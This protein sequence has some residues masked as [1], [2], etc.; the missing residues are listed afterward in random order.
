M[1]NPIS[2]RISSIMLGAKTRDITLAPD[3]EVS[4]DN[5]LHDLFISDLHLGGRDRDGK[6]FTD[7]DAVIGLLQ[8]V[9]ANTIHSVGDFAQFLRLLYWEAPDHD[10]KVEMV[11]KLLLEHK[12]AGAT[13]NWYGGNHDP[14][15]DHR[16]AIDWQSAA[17]WFSKQFPFNLMHHQ[18][19][20]M[21]GGRY[22]VTHGQHLDPRWLFLHDVAAHHGLKNV[23]SW[24]DVRS[25]K[26]Q[27]VPPA[28]LEKYEEFVDWTKGGKPQPVTIAVLSD[29]LQEQIAIQRFMQ[30]EIAKI[31]ELR[32]DN[33]IT[34]TVCGHW[35]RPADESI[36]GIHH[37]NTG[38]WVQSAD[39]PGRSL[40]ATRHKGGVPMLAH[41]DAEAGIIKSRI[42]NDN[43]AGVDFASREKRTP[44]VRGPHRTAEWAADEER[45]LIVLDIDGT[46]YDY[47]ELQKAAGGRN[48]FNEAALTAARN[49]FPKNKFPDMTDKKILDLFARSFTQRN[50]CASAFME[51]AAE[52]GLDADA[53]G[54]RFSRQYHEQLW[55]LASS[56]PDF[57]DHIRPTVEAIKSMSQKRP[58]E[59]AVLTHSHLDA[60]GNPFL[61]RAGLSAFIPPE[62]RFSTKD[63]GGKGK[64]ESAAPVLHVMETLGY[65]AQRTILVEDKLSNKGPAWDFLNVRGAHI[66]HG[67][68]PPAISQPGVHWTHKTV[69]DFLGQIDR[70]F[71]QVMRWRPLQQRDLSGRGYLARLQS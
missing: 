26:H 14:L 54:E 35:H 40:I 8:N 56:N 28:L 3:G 21:G 37:L 67:D 53:I 20:T 44:R 10:E 64:S 48:L 70:T 32:P 16:A 24:A 55:L 39:R 36:R 52:K 65:P 22:L 27:E 2:K 57:F 23:N 7:V 33:Q 58:V 49:V 6:D 31:N 29:K 4:D 69:A 62:N 38:H 19:L 51:Y 59:F 1:S 15:F 71:D 47:A 68:A 61:E 41:W 43:L 46:L 63:V 34:G 9:R 45:L 60:W 42:A 5:R 12:R 50:D 30:A 18:T 66:H 25:I 17:T 11:F 13:I